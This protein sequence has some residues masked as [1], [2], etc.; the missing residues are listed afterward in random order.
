MVPAMRGRGSMDRRG[1][2]TRARVRSPFG[3]FYKG[4][5]EAQMIKAKVNQKTSLSGGGG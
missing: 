4:L 5:D 1:G 2:E 3:K